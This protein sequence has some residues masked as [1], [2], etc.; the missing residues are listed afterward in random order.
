MSEWGSQWRGGGRWVVMVGC[1]WQRC[2][3]TLLHRLFLS[4]G[5]CSLSEPQWFE[6]LC[7]ARPS[8]HDDQR[9]ARLLRACL[10]TDA[11]LLRRNWMTT[12]ADTD[13]SG[14]GT[15]RSRP[16]LQQVVALNPKGNGHALLDL[17]AASTT[18]PPPFNNQQHIF[19]YR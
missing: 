13:T 2:G 10:L 7:R 15:R 18:M 11:T 14:S 19:L 9:V 12:T 4:A 17:A 16:A 5:V 1:V 8:L 3:S 6:H